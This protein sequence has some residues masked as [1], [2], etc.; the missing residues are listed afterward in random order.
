ME[1]FVCV[2]VCHKLARVRSIADYCHS[3]SIVK[4]NCLRF[5]GLLNHLAIDKLSHAKSYFLRNL[6][7]Y[8]G[9]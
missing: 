4:W 1:D 8:H 7:D 5:S 6:T 2:S 3:P 9:N